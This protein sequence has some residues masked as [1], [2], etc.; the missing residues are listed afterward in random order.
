MKVIAIKRVYLTICIL[1]TTILI[2]FG[3]FQFFLDHDATRITFRNYHEDTESIYPAMSVCFEDPLDEDKFYNRSQKRHYEHYLQGKGNAKMVEGINYDEVSKSFYDHLIKVDIV[4][5]NYTILTYNS[6]ILNMNYS[7]VNKWI[8]HL[9]ISFRHSSYKCWT[10][11]IPFM[12]D[13]SILKY[14]I[15]FRNTVFSNGYRPSLNGFNVIMSYPGQYLTNRLK[16]GHWDVRNDRRYK[17]KSKTVIMK[18][19]VQN[20]VVLKLRNKRK[21]PCNSKWEN[22]DEYILGEITKEIGCKPLHWKTETNLPDCK[23]RLQMRKAHEIFGKSGE[24]EFTPPCRRL[25]KILYSYT[26][27]VEMEDKSPPN[28]KSEIIYEI[29]VE[30][31]GGTYMEVE[32]VRAISFHSMVG[33]AGGYIGLFLGWALAHLPDLIEKGLSLLTTWSKMKVPETQLK[34]HA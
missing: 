15:Q 2:C 20:V 21:K 33:N 22:N 7:K 4:L 12:L 18:F 26:D 32:H 3:V 28:N 31:E 1:S 34:E 11:Q 25:E 17:N 16:R 13:R 10:F 19:D 14:G 29:R 23:S 6:T 8:P 27:I 5:S 30:F 24:N 9:Y